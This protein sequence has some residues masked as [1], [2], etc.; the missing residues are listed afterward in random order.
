MAKTAKMRLVEL[1]VLKEDI[2]G[3]IECLGKKGNFQFQN[4]IE[5]NAGAVN[6]DEEVLSKLKSARSF[7]NARDINTSDL[8]NFTRPTEYDRVLCQKFLSVVE[9]LRSREMEAASELKK[10]EDA[11]K[12]AKSFANLK[13][14]YSQFEQM[15]FLTMKIGQIDPQNYDRIVEETGGRAVVVPLGED[16]SRILVATSK[17]GRFSVDSK[18]KEAGFVNMEI[19]HDFKGVPD[20]VLAGLEKQK[21][22]CEKKVQLLEEEKKNMS[23]THK[24][25][26][27]KFL[28]A[29]SIGAQICSLKNSLES[30]DLV[31]RLT[32]W[33]P[34]ADCHSLMKELDALSQGRVAI[35]IFEPGEVNTV[36]TGNEKVPVKLHHGKFIGAFERMIFSYGSPA[37]G[38]I[39]PTPF[40][41][42]FFTLLFGIMFGDAGQ[43]LVF[44]LLGILMAAKVIKIGNWNKFAPV[45]IA[46]GC[47]SMI[48]GLLTGEFFATEGALDGIS[49]FLTGLFGESRTPIL[50]MKFWQSA[51]PI[52]IIYG[53]FGFTMAVGFVI[54]SIGLIIN[55]LNKIA[56]KEFGSA[57]FGKTGLAGALFFWYVVFFALSVA[58]LHHHP[59]KFDWCFIGI[60]LFFA[61]FGSPFERL[62]NGEKP[63]LEN[64][65]GSALIGGIVE[66]IEVISTYLSNSISF[67]RVGAFALA[68]A[69]LGFIIAKMC[70]IAPDAAKLLILIVGN[71]IVIVLEGM[72]VAIQVIR[73]QYYEFFS[74]FFN[75]TG[76]E[77]KPFSFVYNENH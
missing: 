71:A 67:V 57:F 54:N 69:V 60:T 30:T 63:V 70:S 2:D 36:R 16:R 24:D 31:Y 18:L 75:E 27:V 50:E 1:M 3:V 7:L 74:K 4:Q 13:I 51:N 43:G 49:L 29:F 12:E 28:G 52:N 37:Y 33:I 77:F 20:D 32:G 66:L 72:I 38:T 6:E 34:E 64:G 59:S 25:F 17:K 40:V 48:M 11:Y 62:F 5:S 26:L 76:R 44:F 73:L 53:I 58:F 46:I 56:S 47:S 39:D 8:Q 68:H 55:F 14:A 23:K 21:N 10:V 61:A 22:E 42:M 9:N 41:A 65:I 15:T 19:P 45:F 35:R